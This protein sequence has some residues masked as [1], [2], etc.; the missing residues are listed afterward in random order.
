[1]NCS[2]VR[3]NRPAC[4]A[5]VAVVVDKTLS[6]QVV[7]DKLH[8]VRKVVGN[9]PRLRISCL[10]NLLLRMCRNGHKTTSGVKLDSIFELSVPDFLHNEKYGN[11]TTISGIFNQFCTAHAQK[12]LENY[13]RSNFQPQI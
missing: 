7:H 11:W 8:F 12:R 10:P 5:H 4:S 13:F 9:G 3:P 6:S 2:Y 1:M